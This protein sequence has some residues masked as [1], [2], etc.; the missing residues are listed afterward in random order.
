MK[1]KELLKEFE[2]VKT[3]AEH[4]GYRFSVGKALTIVILGTLCGLTSLKAIHEW[5]NSRNVSVFLGEHYGIAKI[6][7]YYWLLRLMQLICPEALNRR[8]MRWSRSLLPEELTDMTVSLDGKTICSTTDQTTPLHIVSAHLANL[9]ITLGQR[10]VSDKSNEIPAVQELI[11][12]LD[13]SGCIVVADALNCQ[14]KTAEA[15]I[16]SGG[17]YVLTVKGNQGTLKT[18]IEDYVQDSELRETMDSQVETE[19]NG[20]RFEHRTAYF[21]KDIEWLRRMHGWPNLAGMGAIHRE[22]T[23]IKTGKKTSEWHYYISSR[24][25]TV[26]EF[27]RHV[28]NEWSV[29]TMHW[30][31]DVH[32]LEDFCKTR[33]RNVNQSMNIIRKVVLNLMRSYKDKAASKQ[34]LSALM[35]S[36]LFDCEEIWKFI[37]KS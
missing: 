13:L 36:C 5:A 26:V 21:T 35:R 20:G 27:S 23:N 18:D 15:I 11:E 2:G 1:T 9:N 29:E 19:K 30:L 17:D 32:L 31:L 37:P 12:L 3:K 33:D 22:F 8:F 28:R 14:V 6:P 25:L 34:A 16:A 4:N 7:C 10:T 24:A